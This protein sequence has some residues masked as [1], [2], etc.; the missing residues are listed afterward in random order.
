MSAFTST[1]CSGFTRKTLLNRRRL[2]QRSPLL[3]APFRHIS[4]AF[5]LGLMIPVTFSLFPQL[6]TVRFTRCSIFLSWHAPCFCTS[7]GL[8]LQSEM[9]EALRPLLVLQIKKE[10][11]EEELQAAADNGQLFYHRGL[12]GADSHIKKAQ[13]TRCH[14]T[15]DSSNV[16]NMF[17]CKMF[18]ML[19]L[20]RSYI[21]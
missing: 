12:W 14:Q 11:V 16:Y 19:K 4:T 17:S 18:N 3:V 10:D 21:W 9:W 8:Y 6:R 5:V 7:V 13:N 15:K 2:F 1:A 20:A